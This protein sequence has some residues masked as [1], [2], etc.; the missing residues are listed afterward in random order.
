M[1]PCWI[2]VIGGAISVNLTG[3]TQQSLTGRICAGFS[4]AL[5]GASRV[6]M[7]TVPGGME[8][9]VRAHTHTIHVYIP[10]LYRN[11]SPTR[12]SSVN[13]ALECLN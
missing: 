6:T 8:S 4:G 10:R 2:Y 1:S 13:R 7:V 12:V 3:L 9:L 11:G 5:A